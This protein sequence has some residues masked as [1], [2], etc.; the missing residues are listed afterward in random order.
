LSFEAVGVQEIQCSLALQTDAPNLPEASLPVRAKSTDLHDAHDTFVQGAKA[1][2]D[3]LFVVDN[4]NSMS[5]E[6]EVLTKALPALVEKASMA[7]Q[8][9]QLAVTTTDA[10][11]DGGILLGQPAFISADGDVAAFV[12]RLKVGLEGSLN[13]RGLQAAWLALSGY[14]VM[15]YGP[16]AGFSR[17]DAELAIIIVSD[18][19]DHSADSPQ[20]WIDRFMGLRASWS[21][22]GTTFHAVVATTD[23][24]SELASVGARYMEVAEAFG[25]QVVDI[26][27]TDFADSFNLQGRLVFSANDRF[28]PHYPP[29][30]ATLEVSV[31]GTP[32]SDGWIWNATARAVVFD[33]EAPCFP[34]LNEAVE[35]DYTVACAL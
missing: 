14:N 11:A 2:L 10:I 32:C 25:G 13:E 3:V 1:K 19:D 27:S 5:D 18:E 4:S 7:G 9:V 30:P 31:A 8:D 28:Y 20:Q 29:D 34:Q 21:G 17:P 16:N 15:P 6:Q 26:C 24:C 23:S 12:D 35:L 22:V 33:K